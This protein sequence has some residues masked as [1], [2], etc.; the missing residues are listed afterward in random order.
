MSDRTED[1]EKSEAHAVSSGRAAMSDVFSNRKA[2]KKGLFADI[3][4]NN[5]VYPQHKMLTVTDGVGTK[6]FICQLLNRY[7]TIGYD[8]VAMC[9]NDLATFGAAMPDQFC[10]YFATQS[11]IQ[12]EKMGKIVRGIDS[13]LKECLLRGL[14]WNVNYGKHETASLDEMIAGP[15]QGMGVDLSAFCAAFIEKKRMPSFRPK[16]GQLIVGFESSGLHSNGYTAA[17]HALL[18]PEAEQRPEWKG[19][20]RGRFGINDPLPGSET[21]IGNALLAP[22]RIYIQTMWDIAREIPKTFGVNITGYGLANFN[23]FGNNIYYHITDPLKPKPIHNLVVEEAGYTPEQAYTK[24]NMG[25]GFAVIAKR[26]EMAEQMIKIAK[27]KG[28]TA[29]IVGSISQSPDRTPSVV[30]N[31]DGKTYTFRGYG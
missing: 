15:V 8:L 25:M 14:D 7:D 22:T 6:I 16:P 27:D 11:R 23:R 1:Y 17:R 2:G 30:L 12:E 18:T 21:T 28:I 13:A 20:Y 31:H 29:K 19:Q 5:R 24:L 9:M 10:I 26:M 3:G 4:P